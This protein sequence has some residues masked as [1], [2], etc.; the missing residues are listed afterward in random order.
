MLELIRPDVNIDFVGNRRYAYLFSGVLTV[1][2]LLA[3]WLLGPRYG[4]D[5]AGGTLLHLRF[6]KPVDAAA[7][8]DALGDVAGDASV[9]DFGGGGKGEGAQAHESGKGEALQKCSRHRVSSLGRS[10]PRA[11]HADAL[12]S[13]GVWEGRA[14]R[15][16]AAK[17]GQ[18]SDPLSVVNCGLFLR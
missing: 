18:Q 12:D 8:R 7:I 3:M 4:I 9:Q 15:A 2:C 10:A 6:H 5:F 1:A 17:W 13:S 16:F 11:R 14:K